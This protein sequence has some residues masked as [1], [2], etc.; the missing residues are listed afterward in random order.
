M[1]AKGVVIKECLANNGFQN[2]TGKRSNICE[3]K[4]W[5]NVVAVHNWI[6]VALADLNLFVF[7]LL[8]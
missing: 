7:Y 2:L 3:H 1:S 5:T 6:L 4:E 8:R